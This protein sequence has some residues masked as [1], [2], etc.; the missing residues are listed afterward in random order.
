MTESI[1]NKT[2]C[3][4]FCC[5][6]GGTI[7]D[8]NERLCSELGYQKGELADQKLEILLSVPSRIF[9]QTHFFPLLKMHGHAEE[10]YLTLQKKNKEQVPVII[11]AEK[12]V[13]NSNTVYIYAG[14]V[15][16][17]RQKFE[18]ELIA[19]RKAA[20]DAL[21]KNS[22]LQ[23]AKAEL[24]KQVEELD[25]QMHTINKQN[26]ELLQ[27][28]RVLT[29]DL[30]EPVR[31]LLIFAN[32][33]KESDNRETQLKVAA[34]VLSVSEQMRNVVFGLQRYVWLAE[35][36]VTSTEVDLNA[37]LKLVVYEIEKDFGGVQLKI[38]SDKLPV[39]NADA[40]QLRLLFYELLS[41]A[42]R[43]KK[44]DRETTVEITAGTLMLNK[45]LSLKENY[46]YTEFLKID[47]K[48]DG[49]GFNPEYKEQV[50]RLFRRLHIHSGQG[51]GLALC[52]RIV[53]NHQGRIKI[54]SN[55]GEGSVVSVFLPAGLVVADSKQKGATDH[56]KS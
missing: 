18:S 37:I 48:D 23:D 26:D 56:V 42:V 13:V 50:F 8:V 51:I 7:V 44:E 53:E 22:A 35:H 15:V 4:I 30:Q 33:L 6:E 43:F 29:H 38:S 32:L 17:H 10:I 34:K 28:N 5:S 19:A 9:Q 55:E 31:K 49:T 27:F 11:N 16:H 21:N 24:Q 40:E 12:H 45:F 20:E 54:D 3:L 46:H 14:I 1:L 2:P 36:N 47:F 39:V 52:K 25:Q 41:N